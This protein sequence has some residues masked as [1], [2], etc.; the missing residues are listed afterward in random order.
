MPAESNSDQTNYKSQQTTPSYSGA[1]ILISLGI[2]FLL[3]NFGFLPIS[4]WQIITQYWP[5]ILILVGLEVFLGGTWLG[6]FIF[7][8]IGLVFFIGIF[9]FGLWLIDTRF[10][11]N[12]IEFINRCLS[13]IGLNFFVK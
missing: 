4:V 11:F 7:G 1:I 6:N 12:L 13:P 10:N 5:V 3:H 8:L 2:L 9:I